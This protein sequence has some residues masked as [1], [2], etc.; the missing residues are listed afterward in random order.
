MNDLQGEIGLIASRF[1]NVIYTKNRASTPAVGESLSPAVMAFNLIGK[2]SR[3]LRVCGEEPLKN[4]ASL[5]QASGSLPYTAGRSLAVTERQ[6]PI[7][8]VQSVRDGI[9]RLRVRCFN[10]LRSIIRGAV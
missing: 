7:I 6:G 2:I 3:Y 8:D 4:L 1:G 10:V 9:L 5:I